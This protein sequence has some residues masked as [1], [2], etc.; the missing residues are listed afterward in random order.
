LALLDLSF[1]S[2][3]KSEE[4]FS[5]EFGTNFTGPDKK[6]IKVPIIFNENDEWILQF[7]SQ[8]QGK[9]TY[10]TCPF[11]KKLNNSSSKILVTSDQDKN[12]RGSIV[13]NP[14]NSQYFIYEERVPYFITAFELG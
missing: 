1:S 8:M 10:I 4:P 14:N 3:V 9:W 11:F 6:E 12:K 2:K 13:T 5:V 7:S